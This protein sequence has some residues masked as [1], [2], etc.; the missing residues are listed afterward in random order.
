[1]QA[2][3]H[4]PPAAH[5][6]EPQAAR[7]LARDSA[8][9]DPA[10]LVGNQQFLRAL[11]VQAK[12]EVSAPSD[13][14]EHEADRLADAFVAR[15]AIDG[16]CTSCAS[17]DDDAL[18]RKA[19]GGP[20]ASGAS[21]PASPPPAGDGAGE[22]IDPAIRHDYERF[23]GA[24]F[25]SVRVH[26]DT[27]AASS[28]RS[29]RAKAYTHGSDVVF[30]AGQYSPRTGEGQR[31]LAHELAH[32]V[33]RGPGIRRQEE[34][35]MTP[36][37]AT[38][39]RGPPP[40]AAASSIYGP[41][42]VAHRAGFDPCAVREANLTNYELLAEYRNALA[43]V[44]QGRDA[45]GYFDYRNLQRRLIAERNRRVAMGHAW[46][47]TMPSGLPEVLYRI[48]E[49]PFGSFDV[50]AVPG[51]TV[52]GAPQDLSSAPL[53]VRSQF[54]RFLEQQS[55]ERV[56]EDT[57][58]MRLSPALSA[59]S[60]QTGGMLA[61]GG[62][63]NT[64]FDFMV[65]D[66]YG[67]PIQGAG[68]GSEIMKWRGRIAETAF[69]SSPSGGMGMLYEDTNLR[70]WTDAS[71][72]TQQPSAEAYPSF[73]FDRPRSQFAA[74]VLGVQRISVK[75][76]LQDTQAGRFNYF[77]EGMQAMYETSSRG[78]GLPS[79]IANQPEYAGQ[80]TSGP[81]YEANRSAV[82]ADAVM[83]I[84]E[85]D[86]AEFRR[87]LSDPALRERATGPTLW[88][89]RGG[90][91]R[92]A[93]G[94]PA[95]RTTGWRQIFEGAMRENPVN[96][97]TDS[98]RLTFST[99]DALDQARTSGQ[100]TPEQY[101]AAQREVGEHAAGR[102]VGIGRMTAEL[103]SLRASRLRY[104]ALTPAQLEPVLTPE[105]MRSERLGGGIAGEARAGA[106]AGLQG[107]GVGGVIA[108]FT[109][110][111]VMLFDEADHP[112]WDRELFISGG[113]GAGAGGL[114]SATEQLVISS[115]TRMILNTTAAGGATRLTPGLVGAGGRLAGG[116]VGAMFVESISMGL[117]EEREHSGLE[118]GTRLGRSAALGAGSIWAGAA[119]GTAVGGPIGFIVGLAA[120]ALIYYIGE[121]VVPGGRED[122]DA[123]EA[124]CTPLPTLQ[125]LAPPPSRET[126]FRCFERNTPVLMAD[127]STT[128]I[129]K[130]APGASVLSYN[131]TTRALEARK[132]THVHEGP[133]APLLRVSCANGT[134]LFVTAEHNL[135]A[136]SGWRPVGE[137]KPGD[138]LLSLLAAVPACEGAQ[139]A[140]L[141]TTVVAI[142]PLPPRD[143]V[144]DL[145]VEG[146]HTYF[147]GGVLAHNKVF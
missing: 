57:Y 48:V 43:V 110:S 92:P 53:M 74:E 143:S 47:A 63:Y 11:G 79:Y 19:D 88:E 67:R 89:E 17:D 115:G 2:R 106:G 129:G 62:L 45:P 13:P 95:E 50:V 81:Q 125:R 4:K 138:R 77:R 124:G 84:N 6:A 28:A 134:E 40:E 118:V 29:L 86:V 9:L 96:I 139:R 97:E 107:A 60:G 42:E 55:V 111:G 131:D 109:T 27:R 25:S 85:E 126:I 68:G 14:G 59:G 3:Q 12:L 73:D 122:W 136:P 58:R 100:I 93:P 135:A 105:F 18:M 32:V 90:F 75:V 51:A 30:G 114:G 91:R 44:N 66:P 35:N 99:P 78:S 142:T 83:A 61:S 82:L 116:A 41:A 65:R 145:T 31:L 127:G 121:H 37:D 108:I 52:S 137:L 34:P 16:G 133:P 23:Y 1:M 7:A 22:P 71:G 56:D 147:A 72:R 98:G 113:L 120:G 141:A 76:S 24:D 33:Q 38:A 15:K 94:Q 21:P 64:P 36:A 69:S 112:N 104:G 20:P 102:V 144:Y 130:L 8:A 123:I 146:T 80:P 119:I 10:A 132:V 46:L 103:A 39:S 87:L 101:A 140:L 5:S 26:A 117:L 49:G 128:A 54:D 70:T